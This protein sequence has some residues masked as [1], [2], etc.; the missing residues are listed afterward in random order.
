MKDNVKHNKMCT[1]FLKGNATK[2]NLV[3]SCIGMHKRGISN[4][5][6][7][8]LSTD[9]L[10]SCLTL[11]QNK[12]NVKKNKKNAG[13]KKIIYYFCY[14]FCNWHTL[15]RIRFLQFAKKKNIKLRINDCFLFFKVAAGW[16]YDNV[17]FY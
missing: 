6:S 4:L 10:C 13:K 7:T 17:Y 11:Q 12:S 5:M 14:T 2:K 3:K 9:F 1:T 15:N 16:G 8:V